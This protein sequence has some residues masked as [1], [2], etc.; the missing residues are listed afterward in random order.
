[1][2]ERRTITKVLVANRGEIARRVF[3]A[4]RRMGIG[5]VAVHSD[6]DT[7]APF[8]ADADEAVA[9]G[10][11][12]PAESYLRCERLIEA[13]AAAGAD[14][15]HP[16]YGFLAENAGF[17]R[18]VADAGLVWIG[19]PAEAIEAM[20]SKVRAR[21]LIESAGVPV[22]PGAELG[23]GA[24]P[25][26]AAD[27]LGF[28]LLVK[29]SAGG[30]GKGMRAVEGPEDL[31]AAVEAA[32]REA[33]GAFGDDTVFLERLAERPRHVEIQVFADC[34]GN[35]V[36]LGERECSIQRRHQKVIEEAP[37]PA[38]DDELRE[39]LGAA[40][41]AAATAV[42]YIGAGTVEL[43]L[44]A[45]GDFYFLEMNTRLQVEHPV[46]EMVTGLDLV[47]LQ[48]LVAAGEPLPPDAREVRLRGHAVEARLYAEDPAAD[49]LPQTGRL[50]RFELGA[51]EP[52]AAG[53]FTAPSPDGHVPGLRVDSGVESGSLI[54]PHYDPMLAKVIAWAPTRVEAAGRL[55]RALE[56]ASIQGPVTNRAFLA[57]V[58]RHPAFLAGETDTGFLERHR[59]VAVPEVEEGVERLH[60]AAAAL[61]AAA[62]RR[63]QPLAF[64]P[65]GWR[66]VPD[67]PQRRAYRGPGGEL[68][69]SY[70]H[71]RDGVTVRV[72]GSELADSTLVEC[73]LAPAAGGGP[74]LVVLGV[75]GVSRTYEVLRRGGEV[76]VSSPLG[77]STLT[78]VPRHPGA[79]EVAAEGALT[80][81][82]PGKV[83]RLEVG[84]GAEVEAGA[85]VAVLEA[86]KMEHELTAPASGIVSELRVAAGQQVDAGAVIAVIG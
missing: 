13:A 23:E 81:P 82:M 54:S 86:M 74:D 8:V 24:D 4:C 50:E 85:V 40:A 36:S 7:G 10:G 32:R 28:P 48:L 41:V 70:R 26:A 77:H 17:A 33:K 25:G 75:D 9:L 69:V 80:A 1:V 46:T 51:G 73:R 22:L 38:V 29:A 53:E 31:T 61:A 11:T 18:A 56:R 20:G 71:L 59:E 55:A 19:P 57:R 68:E 27:D 43:L 63:G 78:E 3:A 49:Y 37:S 79:E 47:R 84:D 39:R 14:A 44:D 30:G 72:N 67:Q 15:V 21:A 35:V 76:Y 62:D 16:G 12:T 34:H 58:L 2:P 6:P 60:A 65:P 52:D 45:G 42:G 83:V 64:A 66:N 5:T